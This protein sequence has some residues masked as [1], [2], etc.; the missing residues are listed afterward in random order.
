MSRPFGYGER[1][2]PPSSIPAVTTSSPTATFS[3][4]SIWRMIRTPP[5]WPT[6]SPVAALP[7]SWPMTVDSPSVRSTTLALAGPTSVTRPASAP[8]AATTTSPT[9]MPS[10]VPLSRTTRR[11]NSDDSRAMTVVATVL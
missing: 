5:S 6:T 11:R 1:T 4:A 9:A 8:P 10:P 7:V 3:P 2:P